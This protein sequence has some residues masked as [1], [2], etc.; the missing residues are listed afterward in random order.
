[1][2]TQTLLDVKWS[3]IGLGAPMRG[4]EVDRVFVEFQ[5]ATQAKVLRDFEEYI[6]S[7]TP[8]SW[9]YVHPCHPDEEW[10][11]SEE[12]KALEFIAGL[13]IAKA[14]WLEGGKVGKIESPR[15]KA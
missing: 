14:E 4:S 10:V 15:R 3:A 8:R 7:G 5:N 1:M 6:M 13:L 12:D 9:G 11:L 2:N